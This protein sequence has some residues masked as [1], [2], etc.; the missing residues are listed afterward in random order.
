[1]FV[2]GFK[3]ERKLED[4]NNTEQFRLIVLVISN[5]QTN[6]PFVSISPDE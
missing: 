3:L 2:Q 1:M 4:Q 5:S 6:Q